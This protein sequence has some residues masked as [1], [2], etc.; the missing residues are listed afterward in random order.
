MLK[1]PMSPLK[2][3]LQFVDASVMSMDGDKGST[4][5]HWVAHINDPSKEHSLDNQCI[6][7]KQLIEAGANVN[8][9]AQLGIDKMTPLHGACWSG[10]CTNL[11]FIQLLLDHGA[12][13]NAKDSEGGTPLQCTVPSAPGAKFLL[14]YSDNT[15]PDIVMNDGRSFLAL[16]RCCIAQGTAE[17]R[18]SHNPE[19]E[20]L[21][22]Q[23]KQWEE[24]EKLM[25]ERWALGGER[26]LDY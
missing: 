4:P 24:V 8:A 14:T 2:V 19:K 15:D 21:L 16:V 26:V 5:L 3:A 17:A 1:L 12:N 18:L 20:K 9:R 22:F 7:A 23:V 13:P 11:D 10:N 6:L 25:I